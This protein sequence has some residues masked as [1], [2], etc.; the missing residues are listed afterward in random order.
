MLVDE[1]T[2][3]WEYSALAAINDHYMK[4]VVSPDENTLPLKGGIKHVQE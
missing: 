1:Q 3:E 4:I 2:I